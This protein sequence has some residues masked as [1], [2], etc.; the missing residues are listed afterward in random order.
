LQIK[1]GKKG[2]MIHQQKYLRELIKKFGM[3]ES[4]AYDTP[5]SSTTKLDL[6]EKGKPIDITTYRGII[7]SLLYLTASRPDI[8][9]SVGLCA[10]FQSCPKESHLIATKRILR[11]LKGTEDLGIWYPK[12]ENFTL[13]GY[14]D[15][16]FAGDRVSKKSTSGMTIFLGPCLVT[17]ASKK[18][19]SVALS[20]A[21]AEYIAAAACCAQI[22]WVKQHLLDLR[23]E[24]GCVEIFCDN[25][26]TISISN[27]P[28]HHSR[29]K[30]IDIRHHFL[31]DHSE[32]GNVKLAF[33]STENQLA[34]I[35]TKPL[36]RE[37]FEKNRMDLGM[38]RFS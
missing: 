1:Q 21:E 22:L 4:R 23:T 30:H 19:N 2:T 24:T 16:D 27:N 13:L 25:T 20:T 9:F 12:S 35:F 28:V 7:G 5:M 15:A 11:Y 10:R 14:S 26:S 33:C 3:D 32:K 29:T 38:I 17:W 37:Q 8:M 36:A 31:R 34:D 18:Q 6:D